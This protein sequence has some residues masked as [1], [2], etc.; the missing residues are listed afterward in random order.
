MN[1]F[2]KAA[3]AAGLLAT[4]VAATAA[5]ATTNFNVSASVPALCTVSAT[6]LTFAN[7]V[8]GAGN[9]DTTA[10]NGI[11]VRCT[12]GTG[13]T[14][15]L[16]TGQAPTATVTNRRM[17][18]T[19]TPANELAYSLFT[20]AARTVNWG[21][22]AVAGAPTGTSTGFGNAV[23]FNVYGRIPDT[24]ANQNAAAATDYTDQVVVTVT[25]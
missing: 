23:N 19:A 4:G 14:V 25:Y 6:G 24:V 15:G 1:K 16:G 17:R 11:T 22:T 21:D 5:T 12:R 10:N 8:P 9:V 2:I 3:V 7:Y 18:S 20:D 13:Y